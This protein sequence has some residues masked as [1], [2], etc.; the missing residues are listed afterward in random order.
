VLRQGVYVGRSDRVSPEG[1]PIKG[2][3]TKAAVI[4]RLRNAAAKMPAD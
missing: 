4:E 3:E 1:T 2:L